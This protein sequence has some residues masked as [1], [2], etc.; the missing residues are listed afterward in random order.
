MSEL[1]DAGT[2]FDLG[3]RRM[4]EPGIFRYLCTRNN[5]FTNRSQKGLIAILLE[6]IRQALIGW[7]GGTIRV[8]KYVPLELRPGGSRCEVS[9][10]FLYIWNT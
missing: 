7:N 2:Y 8:N 1:D 9:L 5:N 3:P 4:T 6:L 10:L